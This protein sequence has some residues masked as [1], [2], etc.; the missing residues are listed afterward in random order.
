MVS[1]FYGLFITANR[2]KWVRWFLLFINIVTI[3]VLILVILLLALMQLIKINKARYRRHL[4]RVIVAC[5]AGLAVGSL[6]ISQTLIAVFPDESGSH[7]HWNL[8]GV[9][10][11]SVTIGWLLNKYRTDDFM[12]E[13]VYVWELKKAL[14]KIN[15]KMLKLKAAGQQ[16]NAD[17]LLAI[18]YSYAG[19]RLLWE[20]DDNTI[21]MDDLAI[22]QV[23]L[24]SLAAKYHLTLNTDDYDGRILKQF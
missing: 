13:V 24:D 4:N 12:T 7:F 19:S 1:F 14:N 15:R 17:A 8:L 22:E 2:L 21:I 16:G 6:A 18:Q 23:A 3:T 10:V 9:A 11:A 5:V 20:L